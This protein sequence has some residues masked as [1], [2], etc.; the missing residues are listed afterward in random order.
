MVWPGT[1]GLLGF[2]Q[3]LIRPLGAVNGIHHRHP[4]SRTC[5]AIEKAVCGT[6]DPHENHSQHAA[7]R[8]NDRRTQKK[9]LIPGLFQWDHF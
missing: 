9:F 5:I 3:Q 6:C 1:I 7:N 2:P 8:A 4:T